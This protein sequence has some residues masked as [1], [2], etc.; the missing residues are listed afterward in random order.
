MKRMIAA[1]MAAGLGLSLAAP[2]AH[3]AP[4]DP[5]GAQELSDREAI[6]DVL[7]EYGRAFDERRLEDYAN[8]FAD[9]GEWVGGPTV[10]KGPAEVLEM[11]KRTVAE[12]PTAP[13]ARNFHV[14][15][16]MMVAVDGDTAAAWSRYTFYMPGADGQPDPVVTGVYDDK[17]VRVAGQWKFLSRT[18]TADMAV[19]RAQPPQQ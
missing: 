4:G 9:N 2:A 7:L 17:L 12:L 13:G 3:A 10:V 8:L 16:N 18:L 5:V 15:T 14:M 1:A 19:R 11:V 6:R